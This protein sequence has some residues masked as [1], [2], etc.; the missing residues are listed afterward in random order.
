[1]V[2]AFCRRIAP[3]LFFLVL[4]LFG[5][6]ASAAEGV[7]RGAAWPWVTE[8]ALPKPTPARARQHT[9][10]MAFRLADRQ[11]RAEPGGD[12]T[13]RRNAYEIIDRSGLE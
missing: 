9:D 13:Y 1:M 5:G 3:A 11:T 6:A 12:T 10:G 8:L 7:R 4:L 2:L